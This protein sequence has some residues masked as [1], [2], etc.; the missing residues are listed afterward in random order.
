M[1]N[2]SVKIRACCWGGSGMAAV[3]SLRCDSETKQIVDL[4]N[5]RKQKFFLRILSKK[6]NY[7]WDFYL[8]VFNLLWF[9]ISFCFVLTS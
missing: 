8:Y 3:A 2:V 4:Q 9:L 1:G 6:L 7:S 5:C